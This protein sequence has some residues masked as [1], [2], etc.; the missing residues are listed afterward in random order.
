MKTLA[1]FQTKHASLRP[2]SSK[3]KTL[4]E[5][6]LKG[7]SLADFIETKTSSAAPPSIPGD[8]RLPKWL[9]TPIPVGERFSHLKET[10]RDLKLHTVLH[11]RKVS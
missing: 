8:G 7:P 5:A 10:L 6:L 3:I 9:K 2:F 4:H 1:V 11:S